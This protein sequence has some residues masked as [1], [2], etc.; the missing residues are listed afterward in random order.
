MV[1]PDGALSNPKLNDALFP[2][3]PIRAGTDEW[4]RGGRDDA[5]ELSGTE[6]PRPA[7]MSATARVLVTRTSRGGDGVWG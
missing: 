6:N 7:T 1:E 3:A 4:P 5:P 2:A